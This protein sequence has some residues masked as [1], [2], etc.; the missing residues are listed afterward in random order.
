V[1]ISSGPLKKELQLSKSKVLGL[2]ESHV[3]KGVVEEIVFL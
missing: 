2:L 3:G 1:K